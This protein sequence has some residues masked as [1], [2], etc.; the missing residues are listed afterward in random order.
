LAVDYFLKIDGIVGESFDATHKDEI[1]IQSYS[2]GSSNAM[3]FNSRGSGASAGKVSFQDIH[4][5]KL[6][7]KASP[8]LMLSCASG[9]HISSAVLTARKAG[10]K[11]VEYLK[12]T[13]TDIL[14]S[15]F[16]TSGSNGGPA[17]A[18]QIS[19]S[20]A[21]IA[22]EYKPQNPDGSLGTAILAGW[23]LKQNAPIAAV[24]G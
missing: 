7:D 3:S 8:V 1:V 23:D 12:I 9:K 4:F 24:I 15:S 17:A 18:E 2:L 20:F 21:K 6:V 10:E 16:Q 11:P 5:T 22:V 14:V 13:F 19:L